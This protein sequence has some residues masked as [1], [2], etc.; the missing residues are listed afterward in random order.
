MQEGAVSVSQC[1][2][3]ARNCLA[4]IQTRYERDPTKSVLRAGII[5]LVLTVMT[6]W[7]FGLHVSR[8]LRFS[9][10]SI[11]ALYVLPGLVGALIS[12]N[13]STELSSVGAP[14]A[15]CGLIGADDAPSISFNLQ[16]H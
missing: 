10:V 5:E 14:A 16:T 8:A 4:D 12:V 15:V 7:A 6:L 1:N 13:L 9:A 11:A 3:I 2:S